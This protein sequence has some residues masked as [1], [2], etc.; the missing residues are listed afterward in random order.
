MKLRTRPLSLIV[1]FT[2]L[3]GCSD[4]IGIDQPL[5]VPG[6]TKYFDGSL[7]RP[8]W[9]GLE[10]CSKLSRNLHAVNFYSVPVETLPSSLHGIRTVGMYFPASDRIFI[11]EAEKW[12]TSVIRHEMMHALLRDESGH[13]AKYFG[14]DGVCGYL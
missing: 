5:E 13:P 8:L 14:P 11:V 1:A 3:T 2:V 4:V 10:A 6:A 12:N 7:F 9:N